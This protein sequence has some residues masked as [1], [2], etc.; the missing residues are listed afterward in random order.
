MQQIE[1]AR[2]D[3]IARA[4]FDRVA[5][6]AGK[7]TDVQ[8]QKYYADNPALFAERRIYQLQEWSVEASPDQIESLR[9]KAQSSKVMNEFTDHLKAHN[10]RFQFNNAVRSAEQLPL[11]GLPTFSKLQDGETII[12]AR[13][14]GL[15]VLMLVSSR[16][17]P[18]ELDR[19]RPAIEQYLLNE[20]K[21]RI[22]A[23]DLK[24][25]RAAAAIRYVDGHGDA[26]PSDK[27]GSGA[28]PGTNLDLSAASTSTN[29]K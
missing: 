25:L 22:I 10:I 12:N 24:A 20:Q 16:R 28:A 18:V 17:E 4:N 21:S 23:D 6:G 15:Q 29:P 13:Q 3:I 26:K 7:A 9:A 2:R 5:S 8:V 27:P 1:A 19:A 11:A 14:N